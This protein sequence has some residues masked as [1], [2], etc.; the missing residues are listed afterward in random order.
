MEIFVEW[1]ENAT[2]GDSPQTPSRKTD[3]KSPYDETSPLYNPRTGEI[4]PEIDSSPGFKYKGR[5]IDVKPRESAPREA[6]LYFLPPKPSGESA[7]NLNV[8]GEG[9]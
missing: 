5:D 3:Q 1:Y 8:T 7:N 6:K 2:H 4:I 9:D